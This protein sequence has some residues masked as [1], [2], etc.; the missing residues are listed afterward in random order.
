MHSFR[1]T[2]G[3]VWCLSVTVGTLKRV[4]ALTGVDLYA[5]S[6]D[7]PEALG[8]FLHNIIQVVDVIYALVQDEAARHG[9]DDEAFGQA[10][11]GDALGAAVEA[12]VQDLVDFFPEPRRRETWRKVLEQSKVLQER[13]LARAEQ[14]VGQVDLEQLLATWNVSSNNARA[15][16]ASGPIP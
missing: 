12:F 6:C 15:S 10:L 7:G 1:D 3:R 13:L 8:K 16:A 5:L 2:T 11:A 4:R 14:E 9:I